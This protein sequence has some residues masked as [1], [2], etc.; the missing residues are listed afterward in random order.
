MNLT[1]HIVK[2]DLRALQWPLTL[3]TLLI[4]TKL[5]IGVALLTADGTEGAA[6]FV[7]MDGIGN[8]L[9]GL[10]CMSFVLVAA[11]IQE[12]MLVGTSAFW[13]TRPISGARLLKAKFIGIGLIF[14]VLPVLVTLPWWLGCGYGL[15]EIAWAALETV[16]IQAIVVLL[17]LLWAV[18]TDGL[19][20]FLMWTLVMLVAVP[21]AFTVT[22]AYHVSHM[23]PG[24][25]VEV[26]GARVGVEIAIAVL[27]I[28]VVVGHQFLTRNLWRSI[29]MIGTA[30]GLILAVWLWWPWS[31][32]LQSRWQSFLARRAEA[33]WSAAAEPPGLTFA[34][35]KAELVRNPG[36]RPDV[37]VQLR[38]SYRVQGLTD[39]QWLMPNYANNYSLRWPDGFT[40][41]GWS[42]FQAGKSSNDMVWWKLL[43]MSP[44]TTLKNMPEDSQAIQSIPA[45]VASRLQ[46]E[47]AAFKLK[48]RFG[49]MEFD[50]AVQI[51]LQPSARTMYG[52][53]G[54]RIAHV[55]KEGEEL[56]VTFV[57]HRP[58]FLS[59]TM[60]GMADYATGVGQ[61]NLPQFARYL[62]VNHARNFVDQGTEQSS[63]TSRIGTVSI[64]V[65]TTVYRGSKAGGGKRPLLEAI[66]ALNEA[67]F[68]KV[69]FRGRAGFTHEFKV[70][71]LVVEPA[72]P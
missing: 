34:V 20:R 30:A 67:E 2:K 70:D 69:V 35:E 11:L 63:L 6:W 53:T 44:T 23:H 72:K 56:L 60:I 28:L 16:V 17:G 41:Q 64:V 21:T 1:W 38:V 4:A 10:E 58:S 59:D 65:Q 46:A 18:V 12:D 19:G 71:S 15:R 5:G 62:L 8:L 37:P 43:G 24:P 27:G 31:L 51:P 45:S 50:S 42:W 14:G 39:S 36:A 55:E 40:D 68:T 9:A 57:R 66:N 49:L 22:V 33:T 32:G 54:E 7:R 3:W 26:V 29:T 48:A 61:A 47:P 52:T 25:S 13:V